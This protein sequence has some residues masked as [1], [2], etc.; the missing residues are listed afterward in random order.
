MGIKE[1]RKIIKMEIIEVKDKEKWDRFIKQNPAGSL[2]Q[3]W[4][5][6]EFQKSLGRRAWRLRVTE[7]E[8]QE[9]LAQA[10]VVKHNLPFKKSYLY[11]PRGPIFS[12]K[13]IEPYSHRIIVKELCQCVKI[14]A[15]K[16]NSLFLRVDPALTF[17]SRGFK[18]LQLYGFTASAKSVQPKDTLILNIKKPEEEILAQMHYKTRYNIRLAGKKGVKIIKTQDPEIV[19][20]FYEV[21]LKTTKREKF[22]THPKFY[23]KKQIEVLGRENL[24]KVFMA[25]YKDKAVALGVFSF[26]GS[27]ATY[28]H[29]ASLYEYRNI[30]APHLVQWE[31]ILE[32]KKR[33][34]QYFDFWGIAPKDKPNHPWTG[35]TRF[36]KG[37]GGKEMNYIGAWDLVFQPGWYRLYNLM[38]SFL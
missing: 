27:V 8:G 38:K 2:L 37:F 4:A 16:E 11:C 31:A 30:M 7:S 20:V 36:K 35:I 3:S 24:I 26:F 25:K 34:C 13:V 32:A 33:D 5:W 21:L 17:K 28:L 22:K 14:I 18:A 29:G 9:V 12:R 1:L 15:Q 23:Y 6:G 19:D 10:L